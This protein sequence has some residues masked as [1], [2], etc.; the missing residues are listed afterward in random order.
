MPQFAVTDNGRKFLVIEAPPRQAVDER[1]VV[2]TGW[3]TALR[4]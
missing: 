2:V 3:N 4:R 1:M